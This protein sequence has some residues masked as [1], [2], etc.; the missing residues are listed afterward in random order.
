MRNSSNRRCAS[1]FTAA[2]L[3]LVAG[4]ELHIAFSQDTATAATDTPPPDL[5]VRT[6]GSD[7]EGFLGPTG[8]GKSQERGLISP[9][10]ASGPRL[11]WQQR[12]GTGYGM[13]AISRGRLFQF[14]RHGDM[15]RL[16][17]QNA[18]TMAE[19]WRFEYPTAYEDLYGYDNGPRCMPVVDGDRVYIYGAEGMLHCVRAV[20]GK[21]VWKVDTGREFGVITNFFGVGSTPV[22]EGDLL[23]VHVGGSPPESR[24]VPPGALD[25]VKPNGTAIVAFDKRTG[26]VRYR[27][28]DD[29][30]SYAVPRVTT[31]GGRRWCFQFARSGLFAFDP[32]T[33]KQDFQFPWRAPI[34]ESVNASNAVTAG[35]L[36][37]ISETYGPGSALLKVRPGGYDVVWSDEQSRRDKRM[38]THWNTAV[39]IN[40]FLYGSSGR[41]SNN[42]ELRCVSLATGEV[43]WSE[44]DLSRASLT[45]VDGHFVCLTEYGELLLLKVNPEKFDVVS[46]FTPVRPEGGEDPSGL[47]PVRLLAYPA[48]AAPTIAHGLMYV[49]GKDRLVCYEIIP[50]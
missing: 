43:K 50:E 14:D 31:I 35:D 28:G 7:W 1:S 12:V 32:T 26:Q 20:D 47:G 21:L 42:A 29:L 40:G 11:V 15:A 5:S 39:E 46:R 49:R 18:A 33:G 23:L 45:Y 34:L 4:V 8:D 44:P 24:L 37:F 10:P 3:C 41:H 9:W 27:V 19:L 36:V 38:Q 22:V 13:P 16:T 25:L 48:W 6:K 2:I 17:C 30:A